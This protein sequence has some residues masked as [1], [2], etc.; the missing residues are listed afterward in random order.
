MT[1]QVTTIAHGALLLANFAWFG[2]GFVQFAFRSRAAF[3]GGIHRRP[4]EPRPTHVDHAADIFRYLGAMG[5]SLALSTVPK[6]MSLLRG[7][8]EPLSYLFWVWGAGHGSQAITTL[9]V[10]APSGRWRW[11]GLGLGLITYIDLLL[12]SA[13]WAAWWIER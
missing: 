7:R 12:W 3:L 4:G 9:S 2:A 8:H 5:G 13:N 11:K 1:S 10:V 6:L